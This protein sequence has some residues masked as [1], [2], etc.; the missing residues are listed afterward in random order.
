MLAPRRLRSLVA[1]LEQLHRGLDRAA[2]GVA[3]HEDEARAGQGAREFHAAEDLLLRHVAR[4]ADDEGVAD[5]HVE[6]ELHGAPRIDAAEDDRHRVLRGGRRVDLAGKVAG[7]A[8]AGHEPLVAVLEELQD[9]F[10]RQLRLHLAGAH[11]HVLDL[12]LHHV[13]L[14]EA[15]EAHLEVAGLRGLPAEVVDQVEDVRVDVIRVARV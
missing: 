1:G 7:Q 9:A 13:P 11:V 12:I 14:L 15:H 4:D 10:R 6:E 5:A 8:P 2:A 3:H